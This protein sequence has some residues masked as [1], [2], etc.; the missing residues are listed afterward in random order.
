[1][2]MRSILCCLAALTITGCGDDGDAAAGPAE[3]PLVVATT[4]QAA[5]LARNA[6]GDRAEV[7]G[8]IPPNADP[9]DYEAR[10]SDIEA[11]AEADVIVRSGGDLDGWLAEAIE[12]SGTEAKVVTLID[13]VKTRTGEAHHEDGPAE[14]EAEA[15]DP[16]WWHDPRNAV[17]AVSAIRDA[18][19]AADGGGSEAYR[20]AAER[21]TAQIEEL[22]TA[23][24]A[25]LEA[26]PAAERKLV[27]THDALG[28][29]A[30][31]YGIEVIGAVIPSLSTQAQASA[32]AT[33]ELVETIREENVRVVFAESSVDAKIEQAIAR[34]SGARV[35]EPL[36]SDTLGTKGSA[37]ETYLGSLAAN[38]RALVAGFTGRPAQCELPA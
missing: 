36:Y 19:V 13:H 10:P 30:E 35:G 23:V 11:L 15:I 29:Y 4:T 28:Y 22:D 31:R 18:L 20:A 14:E 3:G 33:A 9:H 24:A 32:G 37:G 5:D 21:Y 26:I 1:M 2:F 7:Q 17:L 38:T 25:C 8:L 27:T 6:A 16:H 34:E 12:A